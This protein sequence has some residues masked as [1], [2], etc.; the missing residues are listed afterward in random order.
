[1]DFWYRFWKRVQAFLCGSLVGAFLM[2]GFFTA[3]VPGWLE[4]FI[5]IVYAASGIVDPDGNG[6]TGGTATT[7]TSS[8]HWECI[9]E[10]VRNPTAPSTAGDYIQFATAQ[11]NYSTLG[12][13]SSVSSVTSI[14][15][16]VYH[17][18]GATNYFSYVA[19]YNAAQ[20]AVITGTTE[21]QLANRTTAQWD[22]VTFNGLS[23]TQ[24]DLDGMRLRL[25]CARSG[26]GAGN[27]REFAAYAEVTYTPV[28]NVTVSAATTTQQ[29]MT[30]PATDNWTGGKFAIVENTGSR[31][32]TSISIFENGTVNGSTN[33]D[34][35]RLYYEIDN[36][37]PYNCGDRT[38]NGIGSETIFGTS[39]TDGFSAANGTSTFTGS[40]GIST[41]QTMCVYPVMD[42][43]SSAT[44]GETVEIQITNPNISVAGSGSPY[45][46]P[47]T[48]V[49]LPGTSTLTKQ[50]L[51]QIRYHWRND[52]STEA[53]ATSATGG[54]QDTVYNNF[55]KSTIKRLRLEVSNEGNQT[56]ASTAYR[57]EYGKKVSTCSALSPGDWTDVGGVGGDWDMAGSGSQLT[58]GSVTT[59]IAEA[60]GGVANENT[61]FVGTA[62]QKDTSSQTSSLALAST[63]YYE[64]EFAVTAAVATVA[65]DTY[66]FRVT[67]AGTAIDNYDRYPEATIASDVTVS[68]SGAQGSGANVPSTDNNIGIYR[69]TSNGGSATVNTMTFTAS[70]TVDFVNDID[71]ITVRYDL[72]T[73]NP[74]IC[75]DTA[76]AN[77]DT[78]FGTVDTNG[79][80]ASGTST[81]SGSTFTVNSTQT[82][83]V[84][85]EYDVL[86]AATD[87]ELLSIYF[88]NAGTNVTLN[89][90]SVSPNA[91]VA[92][93]G[94]TRMNKARLDQMH[95]HWRNN[96]GTESAA[97]SATGGVEDTTYAELPQ[98][99][100]VRLRVGVSNEGGGTSAATQYRL[101][102]GQKV[103]TC[104]AISS[105][106]NVATAN[107]EFAMIASQLVEGSDTTNVAVGSGGVSNENTTFLSPNGGQRETASQTG[108][109]TLT[110]SQYVDLEY[111]IQ[112]TAS[113]SEGASYCFRVTNAGTAID[114]YT[115]YAEATIKLGTDF[116]VYRNFIDIPNAAASVT[117]TEGVDYDLQMNDASRAF[118][119]ITN[120]SMTGAGPA[121][122]GN[123]NSSNVTAYISNP[124]NITS[125]ITFTRTGTGATSRISWE[126]VEYIGDVGGENEIVV[127]GSGVATYGAANTTVNTG[128]ITG[129]VDDTDVVPF[130]TGQGNPNTGR[131]NYNTGLS[132]SAWNS[133]SDTATFTRSEGADAVNVSYA[134]VE[135]VGAN[136]KIQ[137]NEHTYASVGAL[138]P[139]NITSVNSIA[140]TFLHTQKRAGGSTYD[141]HAD[142]GHEVYLSGIGTIQYRIDGLATTPA[143][144]H[145][146]VA[147]VIENTQTTGKTMKVW[148][149]NGTVASG[150]TPPTVANRAIGTTLADNTI[151]SIF[152]NNRASSANT[153]FQ[154]PMIGARLLTASTT[155]YELWVGDTTD[156]ITYRTEVV[157]WPTASA[158]LYQN[159][160]LLYVDNGALDPTDVWPTGAG[161]LAENAEM[162]ANDG[163]I[164]SGGD[165][166]IRMTLNVTAALHPAT[167][168]SFKL[169]YGARSSTCSAVSAWLP[170]GN[171]GSTTA[172][173]RGNAAAPADGTALSTDP[174][175][176]GALNISVSDVA[177]TYE[178]ENDTALNPFTALVNEDIEFDWN[179]ENNGAADKTN[180]CFRMVYN[181]NSE[182]EGYNRYPVVRTVG[183]EPV[184]RGWK[185]FG[186][187]SSITPTSAL[188]ATN[189]APVNIAFQDPIKLR[190]VVRETAGAQG[191]NVKFKLQYSENASFGSGVFDVVATTTCT[192]SSTWCYANGAGVNNAVINDNTIS[193]N[194]TCAAGVGSGC[195]THNE[196]NS[197][198]NATFDHTALSNAEFEYTLMH[199]GARANA[200]YYFRLYNVG[201]NEAVTSTSTYPSL[202]T[203]GAELVYTT[204]GLTSGITTEG[205][206]TDV[207]TTPSAIAFGSVPFDT[208][209]EAAHRF[210]I[211]TNAT[212]GYQ[213]L[214]FTRDDLTNTYGDIIPN[215]TTTNPAPAGWSTGCATLAKGCFGYHSGDDILG[216][217]STRFS[218]ND[219]YARFSSTTPQEVFYSSIPTNETFDMIYRIRV[220]E[221]QQAGDYQTSIVY[222]A[223]PIF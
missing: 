45:V 211:D 117:I 61:T 222:L 121:S 73:S 76:Y 62:G 109:I 138:E 26:G 87:G 165:I 44:L 39:D 60:T 83:C 14:T 167:V 52:D 160:F 161:A 127:R 70:G 131:T 223:L 10:A 6:T 8:L 186:D 181:D 199:S 49:A 94:D 128:T 46:Q 202:V 20:S 187:E 196:S 7:C 112:A 188:A 106:V 95:Y 59:N 72:D 31:N 175:A 176:G 143:S 42:V 139:E 198:T 169:Q 132:T 34:N 1:M 85:V 212:E 210:S 37:S 153:T 191:T 91:Q 144:G 182:L 158:K 125:S 183:Y 41:T 177:G 149:S 178:E 15:V 11:Q 152:V 155:G 185:W 113:T 184:S 206:T 214:V 43:L 171:I 35:I 123:H 213:I 190:M 174:P 100:P 166:R 104:S 159:Y 134:I 133:G 200:V 93:T 116:A 55:P 21:Q 29:N 2:I 17:S 168:D 68:A 110:S 9:N 25:R 65:G 40:V 97:T 194:V 54:T 58:E 192:A 219:S 27:C 71:N 118:V 136:W 30:I 189:S 195:G 82:A 28:T 216:A 126:V 81:F 150:G 98:T 108:N 105:W 172:L 137:R 141:T 53:A 193:Q 96:D 163:P 86:S 75:D 18:E 57:L 135:F 220:G 209:Y 217:G 146:S 79:F 64:M 129:I 66:C 32:I 162:T 164:A 4:N 145:V 173:W 102:W 124:S 12:T 154:E 77:T 115:R 80:D 74:Y 151:A 99:T 69:I 22:T 218:P 179:I 130:I 170:L 3:T 92:L 89:S 103:T 88:A 122:T 51:R 157:E 84:Y 101:E 107:D 119:R 120:S 16:H 38:F 197:T 90:G 140:R 180:Y 201:T 147:W 50:D 221:M 47:G 156:T 24:S 215:I 208:N 33:L 148:R 56:S 207:T 19:L 63:E 78:A 111:S 204:T 114:T 205:V 67:N 13:I 48:A 142:F 36:T 23:L 203:E 5:N